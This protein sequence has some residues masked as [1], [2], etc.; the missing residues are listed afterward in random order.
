MV[1]N[2]A[3]TNFCLPPNAVCNE[4]GSIEEVEEVTDMSFEALI[5]EKDRNGNQRH[6]YVSKYYELWLGRKYSIVW[7]QGLL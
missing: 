2:V 1:S 3:M 4:W 6:S 7:F 5:L